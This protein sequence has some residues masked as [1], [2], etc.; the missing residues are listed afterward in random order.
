MENKIEK[1]YKKR[2]NIIRGVFLATTVAF[3]WFMLPNLGLGVME[4]SSRSAGRALERAGILW[5]LSLLIF[6]RLNWV[7]KKKLRKN[8]TLYDAVNDDRV[9]LSWLKAYRFAFFIT[10]IASIFWK[11][12]EGNWHGINPEHFLWIMRI[13]K[14]IRQPNGPFFVLYIAVLSLIGSYLFFSREVKNG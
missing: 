10:Y 4:N 7:H 8:S 13:T 5:L 9:K 11:H 3:V 14:I 1:M 12:Y 2:K 6:W